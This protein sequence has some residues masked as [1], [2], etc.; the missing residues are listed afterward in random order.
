M[1]RPPPPTLVGPL[2]LGRLAA[3]RTRLVWVVQPDLDEASGAH[4]DHSIR[5]DPLHLSAS[6]LVPDLVADDSLR[7][8]VF[9]VSKSGVFADHHAVKRN[10][11]FLWQSLDDR[12]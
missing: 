12:C 5:L 10:R 6:Q 3:D 2:G 8:G 1:P 11:F 7:R 9:E 4:D